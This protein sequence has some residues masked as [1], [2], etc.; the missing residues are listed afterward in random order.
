MGGI[1]PTVPV[2][3]FHGQYDL[4]IPIAGAE[5]LYDD[6]TNLGADVSFLVVPGEHITGAFDPRPLAQLDEWLQMK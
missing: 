1:A 3:L 4:W 2:L 6:W 5:T